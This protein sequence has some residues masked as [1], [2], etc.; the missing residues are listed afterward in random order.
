[1]EGD[2][3]VQKVMD[4]EWEMG[5][6]AMTGEFVNMMQAGVIDPKKVGFRV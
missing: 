3:I 4:S 5:Y 6:D 1:V 2:V